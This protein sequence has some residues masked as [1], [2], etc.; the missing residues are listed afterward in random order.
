[1]MHPI[2]V[3][4]MKLTSPMRRYSNVQR[5]GLGILHNL[6]RFHNYCLT[7]EVKRVTDHKPS[8]AVMRNDVAACHNECSRSCYVYISIRYEFY[9]SQP[10]TLQNQ[11]VIQAQ[12]Q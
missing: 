9:T 2:E 6:E 10:T 8:V 5:E 11:L 12:S 3:A 7:C 1:M 4:R